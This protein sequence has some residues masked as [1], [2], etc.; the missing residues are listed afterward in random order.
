[1]SHISLTYH[2]V[3]STYKRRQTIHIAHDRELYKF[4]YDFSVA[5]NV[6]VWRIGGMP[7]HIHILCDIPPTQSVAGFVK[8]LKTE[9]SKY[10]RS[11][12][13]FPYWEK[14]AEGYG[15]FTVDSDSRIERIHYI[16]SQKTHHVVRSFMDEYRDMLRMRGFSDDTVILGE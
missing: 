12:P 13:H 9:S 1:M 14:W 7:D 15:G 6:R 4:I 2:L 8:L 3:F 10:M 11:N 5:R 16:M